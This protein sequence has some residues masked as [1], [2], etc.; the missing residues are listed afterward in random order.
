MVISGQATAELALEEM[1]EKVKKTW[2]ECELPLN[3][4]KDSK[5]IFILG[6]TEE[7]VTFLEDSMVNVATIAGSRFVGPIR[8]EVE[9]WQGDLLIFQETLD[10]WLTLQK[11]W[12]YLESIFASGDIRKQLPQESTN[13][14][15][16][17]NEWKSTMKETYEYAVAF[18]ACTKE[19]RLQ[20]FLQHNET[21]DQIQKSLDVFD[22]FFSY[23][24]LRFFS[25]R[26]ISNQEIR[27]FL[28]VDN[29][30][31]S[32]LSSSQKCL[33]QISTIMMSMKF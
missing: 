30:W 7:I 26:N 8:E 15:I 24:S 25:I 3:A 22:L 29:E 4:Y 23:V 10:E 11:N 9:K 17:D 32:N 31:K 6:N 14:L 21:L 5:D 16:V 1:L 18:V 2:E 33:Y 27:R 12:M 20:A 28:I 19:G 13:F